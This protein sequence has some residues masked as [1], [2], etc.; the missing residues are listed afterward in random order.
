MSKLIGR[1]NA[2]L[3]QVKWELAAAEKLRE[4]KAS[5]GEAT[6][7]LQQLAELA[8]NFRQTQNEIEEEQ[9]D[10]E[11][12][13]SVFNFREEFFS[14]YYRAKDII[15]S[16]ASEFRNSGQDEDEFSNPSDRTMAGSCKDLR[17]AMQM[18]LETQR[19]LLLSQSA[20]SRNVMQMR[21]SMHQAGGDEQVLNRAPLNVKLPTISVP[22]FHGDRKSWISFKDIFE[23]TIHSR[24]DIRDSVKMQYLVSFLDGD[25]KRLVSSFPISDANYAEAWT[26]LTNF[27][28]KKKFTVFAL[29]REFVDQAE[30]RS[31]TPV[32][33][34]KLVTTSDEVAR[35]LNALGE[36]FNTRDP[37]LIHIL[38]EKLDG[39]TRSLWAQKIVEEENPTF[40]DFLKFLDDRC[41]ALETCTAF[42]KK[43][44]AVADEAKK[45]AV[46]KST[47]SEKKVQALHAATEVKK[48]AKCSS[49]H[50]IHTCDEFKKLN[51][52][53]RREFA[54]KA[55][56]C[57]NCLRS[58]H[59]VKVCTSKSVCHNGDCKQR[60]HTL[61]CPKEVVVQNQPADRSSDVQPQ[62]QQTVARREDAISSMVAQVPRVPAPKVSV[63]PTAMICVRASDGKFMK[64]RALI[65]SGSEASLITEATVN[66]LRLPRSNAKFVVSGL[67]QQQA[68]TT[69][70]LVELVIA[71]RFRE[72]VILNTKA[73]VMNKL[74]STLPSQHLCLESS[75]LTDE[76]QQNLA[77]PEFN[78][79]GPIDVVLGSD[80]FLLILKAGQVR[81]S[82]RVPVAQNTIFGL[83]VS[84]NQAVYT[85]GIQGNFSIVNL[86]TELDINQSLRQ[87]WEQE[88]VPKP[89]QLTPS[90]Q[91]AVAYFRSTVSRDEM[92]RFI[93]RLPFDDSKPALGESFTAAMK[94][95]RTMERRFQREP[96]FGKQYLDFIREYQALNHM[97]EI[98]AGELNV[99]DSKCYYLPHH[100][101]VKA[102]SSTTKLRVVFDASCASGSGASLNDRLLTGPNVN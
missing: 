52:Q 82:S 21:D 58:S 30:I 35:Q 53:C 54:Q 90:E 1:R 2:F 17:E 86:H 3:A 6:D 75:I 39:E 87:F 4:R 56:L 49:E 80:V 29:V 79:P 69:R 72:E 76:V 85:T 43:T 44:V 60:H 42:S 84:G 45:G 100:A 46:K 37:W 55:R 34:R 98:P 101:V 38:L 70:G 26:T 63:L 20:A 71:N 83:V 23:T 28:D 19:A 15:E 14:C 22:V 97:E 77:D 10:P 68:G 33:L 9:T 27:Y 57:Y 94:R 48:C 99:E 36:E 40:E 96:E 65:D 13:A 64:V 61:L 102:E 12:I 88:E 50:P 92:G 81:N 95:L 51:V 73:F 24:T 11:A 66:K 5:Y 32:N 16:Y 25:A 67:G 8:K 62:P 7:R 93:V 18:L 31:V 41:D 59:S 91:T 74:T 89:Q 47:Q 78:R